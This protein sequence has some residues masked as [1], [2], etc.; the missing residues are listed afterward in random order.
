MT[1]LL[2]LICFY[3]TNFVLLQTSDGYSEKWLSFPACKMGRLQSPIKLN[4]T[5]SSFNSDFSIVYENYKACE[6]GKKEEP[7]KSKIKTETDLCGYLNFEKKGV[8][9]QYQLKQFDLYNKM[10]SIEGKYSDLEL[11]I[12]YEK[13]L[14]FTSNKNQYQRIQ[15]TNN[16]LAIVL[17]YNKT[18]SGDTILLPDGGL[19]EKLWGEDPANFN[20]A[21]YPIY[22][23]KKAYFYD[24]SFPYSPCQEDITYYVVEPVFKFIGDNPYT[25]KTIATK[26]E[27]F[28]YE[29][30]I[31]RNYM[32]YRESLK[33]MYLDVKKSFY[34]I[35][36]SVFVLLM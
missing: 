10:H 16:Y 1:R 34:I 35:V 27:S 30:P 4:I 12:I 15:D 11:H 14:G 29:R 9:K 31:Y 7:I 22:Q 32:N 20:L 28:A 13:V 19:F 23:D 25:D 2:L 17:R 21:D 5:H 6:L 18:N 3:L 24:G 33:G 26:L 36:M 8:I